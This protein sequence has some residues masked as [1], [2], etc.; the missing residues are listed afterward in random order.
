MLF[1]SFTENQLD[2]GITERL[3]VQMIQKLLGSDK[4]RDC[5]R[6]IWHFTCF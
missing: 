2:Y 4:E 3:S 6:L 5:D 1:V